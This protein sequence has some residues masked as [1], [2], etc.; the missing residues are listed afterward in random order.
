MFDLSQDALLFVEIYTNR[1]LHN[2]I[3]KRMNSVSVSLNLHTYMPLVQRI[4]H[5]LID[6]IYICCKHFLMYLETVI[7]TS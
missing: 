3:S 7:G 5:C 2:M 1:K 6:T 4:F